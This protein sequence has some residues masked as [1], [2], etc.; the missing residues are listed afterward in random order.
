MAWNRINSF[1]RPSCPSWLRAAANSDKTN[2]SVPP[3]EPH[4]RSVVDD[5][6]SGRLRWDRDELMRFSE[7]DRRAAAGGPA[8]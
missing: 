7:G 6:A 2:T 1:V 5:L 3:E 4:P 8:P